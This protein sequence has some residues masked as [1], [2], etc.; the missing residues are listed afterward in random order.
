[1]TMG[2]GQEKDTLELGHPVDAD[3]FAHED[4]AVRARSQPPSSD[5]IGFTA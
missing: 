5:R 3:I 1:M 2:R 4:P